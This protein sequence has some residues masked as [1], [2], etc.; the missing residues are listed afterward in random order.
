MYGGDDIK[1]NQRS[2]AWKWE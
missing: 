1:L 2:R